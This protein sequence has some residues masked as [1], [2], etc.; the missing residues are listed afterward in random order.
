MIFRLNIIVPLAPIQI[1]ARPF[2]TI[3]SIKTLGKIVRANEP[4]GKLQ[5]KL[6]E[7]N[8]YL[9]VRTCTYAVRNICC[10]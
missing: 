4:R 10:G 9:Y 8:S 1:H 6:R 5:T 7:L 2:K 3:R